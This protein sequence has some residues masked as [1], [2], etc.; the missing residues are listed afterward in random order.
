MNEFL[1]ITIPA[2]K[3]LIQLSKQYK[4]KNILF[5]ANGGGCN[6]STYRSKM[7][8]NSFKYNLQPLF[9]KPDPL[10]HKVDNDDYN[11]YLCSEGFQHLVNTTIHWEKSFMDEK[12]VFDNPNCL[13][14]YSCKRSFITN[15]K[16][17]FSF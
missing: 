17:L 9:E 14:E 15:R 8:K 1:K 4:T 2:H 10:W 6:G 12:F 11:I 13:Y 16:G 3:K 5:S 7:F